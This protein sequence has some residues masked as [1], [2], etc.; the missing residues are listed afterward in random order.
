MRSFVKDIKR[1]WHDIKGLVSEEK[2]QIRVMMVWLS[3]V[4]VVCLCHPIIEFLKGPMG[5]ITK[6]LMGKQDLSLKGSGVTDATTF[7]RTTSSGYSLTLNKINWPGIDV[8]QV[9]GGGLNRNSTTLQSALDSWGTAEDVIFWLS[10][11]TWTISSGVTFPDNI[12]IGIPP[13]VELEVNADTWIAS[14]GHMAVSPKQQIVSTAS[15]ASLY[16]TNGGIFYPEW[17]GAVGDDSTDSTAAIQ[18]AIDN[19]ELN[20][21]IVQQGQGIYKTTKS[22]TI[23]NSGVVW[24]GMGSGVTPG[25]AG[26]TNT[27]T[28]IRYHNT[29]GAAVKVNSDPAADTWSDSYRVPWVEISDMKFEV[30]GATVTHNTTG[31]KAVAR[32]STFRNIAVGGF[33][34]G[35]HLDEFV[36]SLIFNCNF[37][38]LG[39]T[40]NGTGLHMEGQCNSTHIVNSSFEYNNTA[41]FLEDIGRVYFEGLVV[42]LSGNTAITPWGGSMDSGI[43]IIASGSDTNHVYIED[44]H[45]EANDN[46]SI[47]VGGTSGGLTPE[48]YVVR[49]EFTGDISGSTNIQ[50]DL[51]SVYTTHVKYGGPTNTGT[52]PLGAIVAFNENHQTYVTVKGT[53]AV[54]VGGLRSGS[55]AYN[56]MLGGTTEVWTVDSGQTDVIEI[57]MTGSGHFGFSLMLSGYSSV[58]DGGMSETNIMGYLS[59]NVVVSGSTNSVYNAWGNNLMVSGVTGRGSGNKIIIELDNTSGN[60]YN[61]TA[62]I[63]GGSYNNTPTAWLMDFKDD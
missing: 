43:S 11:G 3:L 18:A 4:T 53:R 50:C 42:E 14:P 52:G 17:W 48:V 57:D 62:M 55:N 25:D 2:K 45:F 22:I 46:S 9:Y 30:S 29:T 1:V 5:T 54:G 33:Y 15:G 58:N 26:R 7:T 21:G 38:D 16:F 34:T 39:G 59:N 41:I 63:I 37:G 60:D 6:G 36:T 32:E 35:F 40:G 31:I 24:R 47:Y 20:G 13:G 12:F 19:V 44:A 49:S 56:A 23:T 28:V 51:G 8:L 61:I 10:P 27:G